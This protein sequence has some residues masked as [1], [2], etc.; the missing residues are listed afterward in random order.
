M[1]EHIIFCVCE[2][3]IRNQVTSERIVHLVIADHEM[4]TSNFPQG[5]VWVCMG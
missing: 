3:Q 1:Y 4:A 5:F 2:S